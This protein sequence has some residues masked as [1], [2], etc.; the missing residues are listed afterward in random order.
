[1]DRLFGKAKGDDGLVVQ[2]DEEINNR[3]SGQA[4]GRQP[5][6][7]Q[8]STRG[9]IEK[10]ALSR[11]GDGQ[12]E[13]RTGRVGISPSEVSCSGHHTRP[14]QLLLPET[15]WFSRTLLVGARQGL[16]SVG[17]DEL[18]QDGPIQC[19]FSSSNGYACAA[20]HYRHVPETLGGPWSRQRDRSFPTCMPRTAFGHSFDGSIV[21]MGTVGSRSPRLTH[22]L[23]CVEV[24]SRSQR[25]LA[26]MTCI[27]RAR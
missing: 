10:P 2:E 15:C 18:S 13:A 21:V 1:M 7:G 6:S 9:W 16:V 17:V 14:P 26:W 27:S 4:S 8:W 12:N 23:V 22:V 24:S 3:L 25:R 11:T 19:H 20:Q 5:A